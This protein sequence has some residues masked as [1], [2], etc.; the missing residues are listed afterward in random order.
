MEAFYPAEKKGDRDSGIGVEGVLHHESLRVEFGHQC[1]RFYPRNKTP[2]VTQRKPPY[3]N[4]TLAHL[5]F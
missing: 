2:T 3:A 4:Y 1:R 5:P